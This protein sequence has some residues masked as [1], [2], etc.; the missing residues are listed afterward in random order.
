MPAS[1]QRDRME[2]LL[3]QGM[4]GGIPSLTGLA[5]SMQE[6]DWAPVRN[7][8]RIRSDDRLMRPSKARG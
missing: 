2:T 3:R 7:T 1:I 4:C 6:Q 5:A 8:P